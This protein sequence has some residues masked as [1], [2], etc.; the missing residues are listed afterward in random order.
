[1]DGWMDGW[2]LNEI[3]F[4]SLKYEH[5]ITEIKINIQAINKQYISGSID[6]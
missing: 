1:M 5:L 6:K 2:M 4:E 3:N